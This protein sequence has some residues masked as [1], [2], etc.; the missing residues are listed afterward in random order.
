MENV[1]K[2]FYEENTGTF[3]RSIA[4]AKRCA[5]A[6]GSN[7]YVYRVWLTGSPAHIIGKDLVFAYGESVNTVRNADKYIAANVNS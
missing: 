4:A 5:E 3:H 2:M 6:K 1:E 7:P